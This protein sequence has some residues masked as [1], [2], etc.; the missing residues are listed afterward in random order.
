MSRTDS[1]GLGLGGL[2]FANELKR[3]LFSRLGAA[4]LLV[5]FTED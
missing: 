3:L 2:V 4:G 5:D 1:A